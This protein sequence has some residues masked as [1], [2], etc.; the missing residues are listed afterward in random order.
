MDQFLKRIPQPLKLL[1][2]SPYG[3]V[4]VPTKLYDKGI[5]F[6]ALPESQLNVPGNI[7]INLFWTQMVGSRLLR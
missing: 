7:Q 1:I 6:S 2:D 4:V 3:E 5:P